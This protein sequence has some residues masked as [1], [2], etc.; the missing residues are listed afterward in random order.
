MAESITTGQNKISLDPQTGNL[1][2]INKQN[3]PVHIRLRGE[4]KVKNFDINVSGLEM[5]SEG[6]EITG[7]SGRK[8]TITLSQLA[9]LINFANDPSKTEM[10]PP[11]KSTEKIGMFSVDV[12]VFAKKVKP[13][14]VEGIS[15][16]TSNLS[17]TDLNRLVKKIVSENETNESLFDD[18]KDFYRGVKGIKRG[19]GM[20]YFKNMSRLEILIKKLK[21]L[22]V[23]NES[24]MNELSSLKTKVSTLNIP[25]QR[26]T[27]I[28]TLIDNSIFHFKK[29][30]SIN[31]QILSQ[32]KTLN[33]DNWS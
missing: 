14:M 28:I 13:G 5:T 26:K 22:D 6:L 3:V 9:Q 1:I 20:D 7:R 24:V 32:I 25:Q 16:K 33:L 2:V 30:S 29:Y 8:R 19:Y 18:A 10:Q 23:P 21:K 17:E 31:D 4:S 27:A 11:F 12:S 15:V